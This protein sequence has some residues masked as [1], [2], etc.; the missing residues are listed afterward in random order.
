MNRH[1]R[2]GERSRWPDTTLACAYLTALT[3]WAVTHHEDPAAFVT[4]PIGVVV[5]DEL[6]NVL[7]ALERARISPSRA[8]GAQP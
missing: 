3:K 2:H 1:R 4:L 6:L 7:R 8:E 5:A